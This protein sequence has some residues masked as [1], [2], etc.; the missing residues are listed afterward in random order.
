MLN[1][2]VIPLKNNLEEIEQRDAKLPR[3]CDGGGPRPCL[4]FT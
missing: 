4:V 2:Y 1:S 3:A